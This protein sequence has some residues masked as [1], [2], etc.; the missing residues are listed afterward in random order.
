MWR[1]ASIG[2]LKF[3]VPLIPLVVGAFIATQT[4][5]SEPARA[6][7]V[8]AIVA[9]PVSAFLVLILRLKS[10]FCF[11]FCA[12][13]WLYF[14][15]LALAFA[16]TIYLIPSAWTAVDLFYRPDQYW[17][18]DSLY[19]E[20]R[21]ALGE[22]S[23]MGLLLAAHCFW[24]LLFGVA[25]GI[26]ALCWQKAN[27]LYIDRSNA[28]VPPRSA[29][30]TWDEV[31]LFAASCGLVAYLTSGWGAGSS[32]LAVLG[33]GV[34]VLFAGTGCAWSFIALCGV[35]SFFFPSLLPF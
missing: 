10:R 16:P 20:L 25:G 9:L 12:A 2:V 28:L 33:Y 24:T 26:A 35:G 13:A 18:D 8:S 6:M 14:F 3:I 1:K 29:G 22:Y 31:L 15:S 7:S 27:P 19:E 17:P 32:L 5:A 4:L 30:F 11:G 21:F 23:G 34:L